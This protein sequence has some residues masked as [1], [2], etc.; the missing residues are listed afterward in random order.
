MLELPKAKPKL[1]RNVRSSA[2][3]SRLLLRFL[4]Q[5]LATRLLLSLAKH[6]VNRSRRR[7]SQTAE[8]LICRAEGGPKE[9]CQDTLRKARQINRSQ[10]QFQ[11]QAKAK[12]KQNCIQATRIATGQHMSGAQQDTV[13][14]MHWLLVGATMISFGQSQRRGQTKPGQA[15]QAGRQGYTRRQGSMRAASYLLLLYSV[16]YACVWALL[17]TGVTLGEGDP[18]RESLSQVRPAWAA[19]GRLC[20]QNNTIYAL[21]W[22]QSG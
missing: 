15:R 21:Y 14:T 3:H 13:R 9:G 11:Y 17:S 6:L 4:P 1:K 22:E 10:F 8:N 18:Q 20:C 19:C 5:R 2:A 16:L 12:A 7:M